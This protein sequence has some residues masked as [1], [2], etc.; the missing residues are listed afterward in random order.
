M[1]EKIAVER[2]VQQVGDYANGRAK[3]V[4]RAD[5][6]DMFGLSTTTLKLK[7]FNDSHEISYS[8]SANRHDPGIG[9]GKECG[10]WWWR[11]F[12]GIN[13]ERLLNIRKILGFTG[14]GIYKRIDENRELLELLERDAPEFLA[15]HF[16]VRGWLKSHDDFFVALESSVPVTD[17]AFL[18]QC[19]PIQFPRDWPSHVPKNKP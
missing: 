3:D 8:A 1:D 4:A 12:G 18:A 19:T 17:G 10:K 5:D 7:P 6:R 2:L 11:W 9:A 14:G 15:S 16:W 13:S